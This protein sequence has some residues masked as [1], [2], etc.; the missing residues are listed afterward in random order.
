AVERLHGSGE[1]MGFRL[2][3]DDSVD[4]TGF[5]KVCLMLR[6][7]SKLL[8]FWSA[9]K[10]H[11]VFVRRSNPVRV[12]LRSF[13]DQLKKRLRLLFPIDDKGTIEDLVAAVLGVYL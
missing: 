1:V 13:F 3:R 9:D 10:G 11:I 6:I 12:L 2:Q 8:H 7:R 4:L 5:E